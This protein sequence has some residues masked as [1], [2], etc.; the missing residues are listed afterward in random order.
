[1]TKISG[2]SFGPDFHQLKD[3]LSVP[4]SRKEILPAAAATPLNPIPPAADEI[5]V[6]SDSEATQRILG[7]NPSAVPA[8]GQESPFHLPSAPSEI[9]RATSRY[10][11]T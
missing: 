4:A 2:D 10:F 5:R 3:A 9:D 1:M 11:C 7:L 6:P 8:A